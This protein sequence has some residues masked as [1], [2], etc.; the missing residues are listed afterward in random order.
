MKTL[1]RITIWIG[2]SSLFLAC[3]SDF[4]EVTPAGK[5]IATTTADYDLLLNSLTLGNQFIT[6]PQA[7]GDEMA[8]I[9][10]YYV[11]TTIQQQRAFQW[12]NDIYEQNEDAQEITN[13][14]KA[15]YLYNIV[16]NEVLASSDGTDAQKKTLQAEALAGRAWTY[17]QLINLFAPPYVSATA[18]TDKGFPIID[19]ANVL[20]SNFQRASVQDVYDFI[21]DDLKKALPY[22][23]TTPRH[24]YRMSK[25]A[26]EA[27]LGKVYLFMGLY[28]LALPHLNE[29]MTGI[30]TSTY[31]VR[32]YDYNITFGPGGTFLPI[33]VFGPVLPNLY[34]NEES[35][36]SRQSTGD[37]TSASNALVLTP[38]TMALYG[39]SDLRRNFLNTTPYPSGAAFP[40]G[41]ARKTGPFSPIIGMMVPD[42]YLMRAEVKARLGDLV[43]A[44]VDL[45]AL[46]IKRMPPAAAVVPDGIAGDRIGLVRFI[47]DERIRE[48]SGL[49]YRWH[50]MRR[51]SVDG[52]FSNT[53]KNKHI[54]YTLAGDITKTFTLTA[55]RLTFKI[56][57]KVLFENPQMEDND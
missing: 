51:L 52:E 33:S 16:I 44:K 37:W 29:A 39:A 48:F 46:R 45:E 23:D 40:L 47:L 49:G 2:I 8:G 15:L 9:E 41:M 38:E 56:P 24:R 34:N 3:K 11:G 4:L 7:M 17:F 10:S 20:L 1:F 36:Y 54:I 26:A 5:L 28:D 13:P 14:T 35:L 32:L 21:I 12:E 18:A 19:K 43:G 31:P 30:S 57:P 25:P 50:D 55:D 53:V 22:L 27:L 42:V 6:K